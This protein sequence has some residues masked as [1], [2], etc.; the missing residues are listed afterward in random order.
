MQSSNLPRSPRVV[1]RGVVTRGTVARGIAVLALLALVAA[2]SSASAPAFR[3][4]GVGVGVSG[5]ASVGT[6]QAAGPATLPEAIAAPSA[7]A[8]AAPASA[9]GGSSGSAAVALVDTPYIVR[10]GSLTIEVPVVDDALLKARTA[11]VGLGGYISGSQESNSGDRSMASVTY[12]IPAD[13][14]EAALDALRG[15]AT[16]V[17]SL[18]TDSTEV[19]GQVLDLG[20]RIDNLRVT[21]TALQAVMTKA[22]KIQDI[23]DVQNQLT[24]VQGQI[25]ELTTEQN[26]LKDQAA[27]SSL[28][29][30]F[31]APPPAAVRETSNGWDPGAQFDQAAAQLLAL[32]QGLATIGIWSAVVGLPILVGLL[33]VLLLLA[34]LARRIPW[35]ASRPAGP[36]APSGPSAQTGAV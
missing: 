18:T 9:S 25:E 22:T 6:G 16:K 17:D 20:A 1:N 32:G 2:C 12:R 30:L 14:W 21:E 34:V 26:H 23:L 28:T 13:R 29:V 36:S 35:R 11:I 3:S 24:T 5:P 15:I 27:M 10:T 19:T 7:A 33:L 31:Q 8:S 4:V